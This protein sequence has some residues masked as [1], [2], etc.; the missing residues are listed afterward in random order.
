MSDTATLSP[1]E[2]KIEQLLS[3]YVDVLEGWQELGRGADGFGLKMMSRAWNTRTY[4]ELNRCLLALRD[5]DCRTY[6]HV[7][8]RWLTGGWRTVLACPSCGAVENVAAKHFVEGLKGRHV[9]LKHKHAGESVFFV[10]R[11]VPHVSAAVRPEVVTA[12]VRWLADRFVGEPF[13]PLE[14]LGKERAA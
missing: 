4:Q 11:S 13:I 10:L 2:D 7:R 6:W 3:W 8:E 1:K 12:G 5:E 9:V 14:L